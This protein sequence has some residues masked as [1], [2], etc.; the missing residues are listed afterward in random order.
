[1]NDAGWQEFF[2][3]DSFWH[4]NALKVRWSEGHGLFN[5]TRWIQ[6][7]HI[8][9]W[10]LDLLLWSLK[11]WNLFLW[12]GILLK[13]KVGQWY[14]TEEIEISL[15]IVRYLWLGKV[16]T[17]QKL[18]W[19]KSCTIS[20]K[21]SILIDSVRTKL[22]I[23]KDMFS[24][25]LQLQLQTLPSKSFHEGPSWTKPCSISANVASSRSRSWPQKSATMGWT[26]GS[27]HAHEARRCFSRLIFNVNYMDVYVGVSTAD[28]CKL[29]FVKLLP[30]VSWHRFMGFFI[31]GF[32]TF[33]WIWA[34]WYQ[35]WKT[36]HRFIRYQ[37][38]GKLTIAP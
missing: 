34:R 16:H 25:P 15:H 33:L 7:R 17:W 9:S 18:A 24:Q 28:I 12:W 1:M 10:G 11:T 2:H 37:S 19:R 6:V 23:F 35:W 26:I 4:R 14:P 21:D 36:T 27:A 3:R 32:W 8:Q 13:L 31:G 22:S 5:L 38:L 20:A 30:M 29:C